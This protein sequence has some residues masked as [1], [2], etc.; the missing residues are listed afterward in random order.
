MNFQ[1]FYCKLMNRFGVLS[2]GWMV[3]CLV[4]C[5]TVGALQA[6]QIPGAE[7]CRKL[8]SV[9]LPGTTILQAEAVASGTFVPP[10][11]NDKAKQ[12][13]VFQQ[14]P[15]FCRVVAQMKPSSDSAINAEVWM[16]LSRWNRKYHGEGNGGFAGSISYREMA[17]ALKQGYATAGTDT[18]HQ[19]EATDA[20]W[21]LHHPEKIVDFGYRA[22]HETAEKA[23]LLIKAFYGEAPQHSYFAA[24]SDGGREALMEAQRFPADYDGILAGAPANYWTHLLAGGADVWSVVLRSQNSFVPP[25][26][27]P[28]ISAAVLA[29]CDA[30][31]GVKDGILNDPSQCHF[32]PSVLLCKGAESDRCLTAAQVQS[33]KK[34]Y[35]GGRTSGNRQIFPGLLPGG[36]E[37]N[38]GW[39]NWVLGAAPGKSEGV[40]YVTGFFRN[41]VY[42]DPTWTY[43]KTNA[44]KNVEQAD[45]KMS[46][47][48][49]STNPDLR[50]FQKRGGKLILYHGWND[51]AIS[52]L[53][54][55]NYYRSVQAKMGR[56][57]T[58]SFVHLYL[59]PGMQHCLGGPGPNVFGQFSTLPQTDPQHNAYRSLEQWVESGTAPGSIIATKYT[60]EKPFQEIQMTRPLCVYPQIAKYKGSGSTNDAAN[61]TCVAPG[62]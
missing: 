48:L 46:Q 28:A 1:T 36:E 59:V 16:P 60:D 20:S 44:D 17:A 15:P 31:D 62:Q 2:G 57:A 27:V 51:P 47:P 25:A 39:K 6:Q 18:G 10:H 40:A 41:M 24:C 7:T 49:N 45:E 9:S 54:T 13:P 5:F 14:M 22:I 55:I 52:A 4:V 35:A 26:K 50:Q 12:D 19:G 53:N 3:K 58:E 42:N 21:A 30:Q 34:I 43:L 32:D 38:G 33:L 56:A 8:A 11:A 29:A 23:K 61:F 37:G